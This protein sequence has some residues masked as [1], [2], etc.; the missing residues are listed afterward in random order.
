MPSFLTRRSKAASLSTAPD[1]WPTRRSAAYSIL[2]FALAIA[3]PLVLAGCGDASSSGAGGSASAS[4]QAGQTQG[5]GDAQGVAAL[6][7]CYRKG[8]GAPKRLFQSGGQ[9]WQT[10]ALETGP[11]QWEWQPPVPM[12]VAGDSLL[13]ER[14]SL[15]ASWGH[16]QFGE[17]REG[18]TQPLGSE[19][20]TS[21]SEEQN[22]VTTGLY[23]ASQ[24]APPSSDDNYAQE[25]F[26]LATASNAG[27]FAIR[28]PS[29]FGDAPP[30]LIGIS[31]SEC[32]SAAMDVTAP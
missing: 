20:S 10:Y 25:L 12:Q 24:D 6:E 19:D 2:S 7:G 18:G 30:S 14:S 5:S 21:T 32:P 11:N 22:R 1:C 23:V 17:N 8:Q 13:Q 3:A 27:S 16:E 15:V 31:Q 9:W 4:G 26:R 29:S 28:I